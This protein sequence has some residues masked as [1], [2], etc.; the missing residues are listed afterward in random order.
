MR[1]RL[2]DLLGIEHPVLSGG[3]GAATNVDLVVAVCEGG[4]L[5]ILG[6]TQ[7]SP[8][9]IRERVAQIRGRTD[10]PFGINL[11][12]AFSTAEQLRACVEAR[13]P[14]LSTAWGDPAEHARLARDAGVPLVH[15][16][17][18]AAQAALAARAGATVVVAQ[19]HE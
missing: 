19:G 3:M 1:T 2:T 14:V 4:G 9:E 12:I 15:M 18:T 17:P 8:A 11:L 6:A 16:V 10:R 13:A 5:G 7:L